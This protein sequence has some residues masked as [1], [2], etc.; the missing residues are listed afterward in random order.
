MLIELSGVQFGLEIARF[1][2]RTA[3][4]ML[5]DR[6]IEGIEN[7]QNIRQIGHW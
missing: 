1:Q 2:N 7:S 5:K 3:A 4:R 6:R